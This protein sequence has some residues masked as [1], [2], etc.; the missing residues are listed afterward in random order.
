MKNELI[1]VEFP[2]FKG[3]E[4]S[5]AQQIKDT[6]LPMSEMLSEFESAY[7][8][9]IKD[10]ENGIDGP[11]T[12]RAKRLRIDI[13]K[14]RTSTGKLKDEQKKYL[15]LEG[16]AIQGVHN[17]LVH[18]VSEKEDRLKEIENHFENLENER[19]NKLQLERVEKLSKYIEDAQERN[20]SIMEE[21]VWIPYLASKKQAFEDQKQAEIKAEETRIENERLDAVEISR[22]RTIAP[23]IAFVGETKSNLRDM[24]EKDFNALVLF[25]RNSKAEYD[26][27]QQEIKEENERLNKEREASHAKA[28]AE[29]DA[30]DKQTKVD[31]DA[32][33]KAESEAKAAHQAELN[34]ERE[35]AA[36]I[37][38]IEQEKREK[39]ESELKAAQEKESKAVADAEAKKQAELSKGDADKVKDLIS[40]LELI[41]TKYKFDSAKNKKMYE[42]TGKLIDK[43]IIHINK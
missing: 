27:D 30:R 40:E 25:L 22:E 9:I 19:L 15:I 31:S 38:K 29:Q 1:K 4:K 26:K 13:S 18:A 10:K 35:A 5:K 11:L 2:E 17:I 36:K 41:K 39:L 37:A 20:L 12:A 6:F 14:I 8:E 21:D 28:K 24:Q 23:Y 7:N 34:K 33:E 16:K 32:R 43:V 3:I 42:D